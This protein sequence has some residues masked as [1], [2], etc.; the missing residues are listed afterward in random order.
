MEYNEL[1]I[2]VL[3]KKDILLKDCGYFLSRVI[4]EAM[5]KDEK[6]L[7]YHN[8]AGFKY[9]SFDSLYPLAKEGVY[10]KDGLYN[11]RLRSVKKDFISGIKKGLLKFQN[12]DIKVIMIEE[13]R[14]KHRKI[15]ELISLT[16]VIV[17]LESQNNMVDVNQFGNIQDNIIRNLVKKYNSLYKETISFD[18]AAHIFLKTTL[19]SKPIPTSYKGVSLL[20]VKYRFKVNHDGLSQRLA[21]LAEAVGIGE[22]NSACGAGFCHAEYE[23]GV[24]YDRLI[25]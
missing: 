11:F 2:V 7:E 1:K 20:G 15:D 18:D 25:D 21:F 23:K 4:I 17:T 16:P 24:V 8:G 12:N 9:Y 22:K 10:S 14:Y 19:S 13:K 5:S 3:L 6:L